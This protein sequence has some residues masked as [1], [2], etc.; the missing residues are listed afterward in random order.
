MAGGKPYNVAVIGPR[1]HGKTTLAACLVQTQP[2]ASVRDARQ[3][4]VACSGDYHG[5]W[6]GFPSA[7]PD[8]YRTVRPTPFRFA[9]DT[10]TYTGFDGPGLVRLARRSTSLLASMDAV[11]VVVSPLELD[12][13]G[14]DLLREQ[15]SVAHHVGAAGVLVFLS[16]CDH[17]ESAADADE[18]CGAAET[19]VRSVAE[20]CGFD[21]KQIAFVRGAAG[22]EAGGDPRFSGAAARVMG[23]LDACPTP[24][25][26]PDAPLRFPVFRAHR[27]AGRGTVATGILARGRIA[28][29]DRVRVVGARR[30]WFN[31]HVAATA[32][33]SEVLSLRELDQPRSHAEA[34]AAIGALLRPRAGADWYAAYE[35]SHGVTIVG[36][37]VEGADGVARFAGRFRFLGP[38]DA[39]HRPGAAY[40]FYAGMGREAGT[41]ELASDRTI[42]AGEVVSAA[43]TL[44]LPMY[45]EIGTHLFVRRDR[46]VALGEVTSLAP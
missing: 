4:L 29:G 35:I 45:L 30:S 41:F 20:A 22:P 31:R 43:V 38:P 14:L 2:R 39:T 40:L 10:R 23:A 36:C 26:S 25:R 13:A 33:D 24:S 32:F 17:F 19:R 37:G 34:G 7:R 3:A 27:I 8:D 42:H 28:E 15:L 6:T 46:I 1:G 9:T 44:A 12:G 5:R 16:K 11:I 18:V 21:S